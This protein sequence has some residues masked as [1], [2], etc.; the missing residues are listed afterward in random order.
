M[1]FTKVA[2]LGWVRKPLA[3]GVFLAAD[4]LGVVRGV[5]PF[6]PVGVWLV[7]AFF[8]AEFA[9]ATEALASVLGVVASAFTALE[10]ED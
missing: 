1:K 4:V 6:R 7:A 3:L 2:L 8:L 10:Y 9:I 5:A